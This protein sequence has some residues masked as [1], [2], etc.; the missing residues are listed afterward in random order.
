MNHRAAALGPRDPA[1]ARGSVLKTLALIGLGGAAAYLIWPWRSRVE[2]DESNDAPNDADDAAL[3][4]AG[5]ASTCVC[6]RTLSIAISPTPST[7]PSGGEV[8]EG[9]PPR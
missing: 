8:G 7:L 3:S 1:P 5:G 6:G 4:V 2:S 9:T